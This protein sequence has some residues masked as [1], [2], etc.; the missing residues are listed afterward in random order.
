[1]KDGKSLDE[2]L[3]IDAD[4]M[5]KV[6]NSIS[7]AALLAL[8]AVSGDSEWALDVSCERDS[9]YIVVIETGT[10]ATYTYLNPRF[11]DR[12]EGS[13]E[14]P[15]VFVCPDMDEFEQ[16]EE[17]Q[18]ALAEVEINGTDCPA[19]HVCDDKDDLLKII[20]CFL[21]TGAICP[22]VDWLKS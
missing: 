19:L 7:A 13:D 22:D 2:E 9:A 8:G 18:D 1:M 21:D 20:T 16:R 15:N 11:T 3:E 17:N 6:K 4:T 14:F 12:F 10:G 5:G